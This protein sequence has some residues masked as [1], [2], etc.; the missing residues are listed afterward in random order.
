MYVHGFRKYAVEITTITS[1]ASVATENHFKH[2][3]SSCTTDNTGKNASP[4]VEWKIWYD[5]YLYIYI[6]R[7][8]KLEKVMITAWSLQTVC[9][10][11]SFQWEDSYLW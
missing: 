5:I 9:Q 1:I 10:E 11:K 4:A 8:I 2:Y 6:Y 3:A 7:T